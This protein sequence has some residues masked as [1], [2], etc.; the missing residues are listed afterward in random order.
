MKQFFTL[1]FAVVLSFQITAQEKLS[2]HLNLGYLIP[3]TDLPNADYSGYDPNLAVSA[4]LGYMVYENLRLRGDLLI[5]N[6]NGDNGIAFYQTLL[7]EPKLALEYNIA[8]LFSDN[9]KVR[10]NVLGGAGVALSQARSFDI[11][12]RGLIAESPIPQETFMS[13]NGFI[14]GGLNFGYAVTPKLE[15]NVGYEHRLVFGQE[16][17][18]ATKSGDFGDLYGGVN[19]GLVFYF[20][21]SRTPN[22]VEVDQAKYRKMQQRIDSLQIVANEGNQMQVARLEMKA[23]ERELEMARMQAKMDSL[24]AM[25]NTVAVATDNSTGQ[26]PTPNQAA[27]LGTPQFRI[28]V[29]SLPSQVQGQRWI[30]R[31]SLDKQDMVVAYVKDVNTYRIV[32]KSFDTLDAA[33]KEL[34]NVKTTIPDAWIIKF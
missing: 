30:D 18:D 16:Y 15:V 13:P 32:Y 21:E 6:M 20:G 27:I 14:S 9:Q 7:I 33:K 17:L 23:K 31:S 28:I 2:G 10:F 29:A 24:R 34:Q 5:G 3:F 11:N 19:L 8:A 22:T 26:K 1:C 25:G 4:G 12:T